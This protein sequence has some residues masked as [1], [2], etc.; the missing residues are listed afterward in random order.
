MPLLANTSII[1]AGR[2]EVDDAYE[3]K[4]NLLLPQLP[5]AYD[6]AKTYNEGDQAFVNGKLYVAGVDGLTGTFDPDLWESGGVG[7]TDIYLVESVNL[8]AAGWNALPVASRD[9]NRTFW[10]TDRGVVDSSTTGASFDLVHELSDGPV[11]LLDKSNS[12]HRY[13]WDG[14]ALVDLQSTSSATYLV[15]ALPTTPEGGAIYFLQDYGGAVANQA[16]RGLYYADSG[17]YFQVVI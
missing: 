17:G 5:E 4:L 2:G 12:N 3:A 8:D 14:T 1:Q 11:I 16:S 15:N 9:N 10:L 13:Q 7:G 6:T